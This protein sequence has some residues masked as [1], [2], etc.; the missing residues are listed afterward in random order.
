[1]TDITQANTLIHII[2]QAIH[3]AIAYSTL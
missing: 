1:M 3:A 2:Q